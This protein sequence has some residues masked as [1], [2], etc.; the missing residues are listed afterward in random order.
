MS[1]YVALLRG[2]NVGKGNR[3]PMAG[4]RELLLS[5]GFGDVAT[6]LNSGNAVFTA[7]R[8]A[9]ATLARRI[10]DG[11]VSA[12][13]VDV[14][15]VVKSAAE[16]GAIMKENPFTEPTVDPS[17]LLVAFV[18]EASSLAALSPV[19]ERVVEPERFHAGAHAAYLD[20]VNGIHTSKAAVAL[21]GKAGRHATSRNWATS[22]RLHALLQARA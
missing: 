14:A 2:V 7:P 12:L 15:V 8:S 3:V 5:L 9:S 13:S 16:F 18:Q 17:R 1:A 20:C 6:L 19:G 4:L 21:L 22:L 10:H 11:L